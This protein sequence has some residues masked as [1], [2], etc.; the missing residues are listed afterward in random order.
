MRGARSFSPAL[1]G[2]AWLARAGFPLAVA[3]RVAEES[4]EAAL[5]AGFAGLFRAQQLRLDAWDPEQLVLF[6]DWRTRRRPPRSARP[7]GRRCT[8]AGGR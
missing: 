7:A 6:P 1:A 2:L 5:R 3:A 8:Q 4:D